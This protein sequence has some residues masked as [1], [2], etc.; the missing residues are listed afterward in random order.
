MFVDTATVVIKSGSGGKGCM[1]FRRE[2][3]KPRGGPD[4]GDGG[5]GG[6]VIFIGDPGMNSLV[7]FRYSPRLFA[8]SGRH[9]SGNNRTGK[10]GGNLK[11]K[12][13]CGT[14]L[15][16][17]DTNEIICEVTEAGFPVT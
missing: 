11:I 16:N 3:Y 2:K 13:P 7:R 15:R 4:G 8:E 14:I 12:V 9:G 5:N 10:K 17:A 1:S 6:D